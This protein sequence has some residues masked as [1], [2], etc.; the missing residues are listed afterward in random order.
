MK[1][2]P[3]ETFKEVIERL[4]TTASYIVRNQREVIEHIR[5]KNPKFFRE[6]KMFESPQP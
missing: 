3:R 1:L 2:H 4:D 5:D 6:E